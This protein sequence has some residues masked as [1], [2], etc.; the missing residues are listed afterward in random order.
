MA[1]VSLE[2]IAILEPQRLAQRLQLVGLHINPRPQRRLEQPRVGGRHAVPLQGVQVAGEHLRVIEAP[3]ADRLPGAL[4]K[5]PSI[6][7]TLPE[8]LCDLTV[9]VVIQTGQSHHGVAAFLFWRPDL[10]NQ[11]VVAAAVNHATL[12][13]AG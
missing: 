9:G 10:L 2:S 4:A 8:H 11:V 7:I 12:T 6:H 13:E 1:R 5:D 3:L